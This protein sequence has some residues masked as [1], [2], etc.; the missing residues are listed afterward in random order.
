MDPGLGCR[1]ASTGRGAHGKRC[2]VLIQL[3]IRDFATIEE[4][5]LEFGAGLNILTGETGAGKS[6]IVGAA[7]IIRGGRSG[8]D[9]VRQGAAE[10]AIEAVFDLSG[11]PWAR[12]T[13]REAG[14][15]DCRAA[16]ELLVRRVVSR[17]GRSRAYL[18]GTLAT[19][20]LLSRIVG[21][22]LEISGQ[23]DQQSLVDGQRSLE[24]LDQ[25]AG[26]G[27]PR[28]RMATSYAALVQALEQL[29]DLEGMSGDSAERAEFLRFQLAELQQVA[30]SP[31]EEGQL[32]ARLKRSR[33]AKD[34]LSVAHLSERLLY[35]E[36]GSAYERLISVQDRLSKHAESDPELEHLLGQLAEASALVEEFRQ[37]LMRHSAGFELDPDQVEQDERRLDLIQSLK[38]KHR[39]DFTGLLARCAALSEDLAGLE[40]LGERIEAQRQQVA[41]K[42]EDATDC[43]RILRRLREEASVRLAAEV[44]GHLGPLCMEGAELVVKVRPRAPRA[45]ADQALIVEKAL[46]SASGTDQVELLA[47]TNPGHPALPLARVASG[48]EL[49]RVMLAIRQVLGKFDPRGTS[50]YDEV[51]AGIGGRTADV[52]GAYLAQVATERQVICVTHLPQV[53]AH[54]NVHFYVGKC[55]RAAGTA[56][57]VQRL[58]QR[59]RV[60]ELARML[61]ARRITAQARANA[62]QL[63][64]Q[65]RND[66]PAQTP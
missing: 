44:T 2:P 36:D 4:L 27:A 52:V 34:L 12:T 64:S 39:T 35:S 6:I 38:R 13:L 37:G 65:A 48:G 23:H 42:R 15:A 3:R 10:A 16:D 40:S 56:T 46:L 5:E 28:E 53:A 50:I 9:V 21:Q 19:A 25:F 51:D 7:A 31:G 32:I 61:G 41:K 60:E 58:S 30:L 24:I 20:G 1:R 47:R 45:E 26:V 63:L 62:R 54:A 8:A 11:Q 29:A 59:G 66:T 18:N 55:R 43:A 57:E 49:S 17:S 22:L 33:G 14:L